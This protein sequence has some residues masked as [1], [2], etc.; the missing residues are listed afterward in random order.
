MQTNLNYADIKLN[1]AGMHSTGAGLNPMNG[2]QAC[3]HRL[4]NT[5]FFVVI[6]SHLY[7]GI[8][9]AYANYLNY[10]VLKSVSGLNFT[11]LGTTIGL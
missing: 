4:V 8:Q 6:C 10:L 2:L 11:A 5:A 3:I 1:I 9:P 7:S